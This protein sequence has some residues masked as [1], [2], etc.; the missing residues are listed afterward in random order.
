MKVLHLFIK[1]NN[2]KNGI[3][4]WHMISPVK[5]IKSINKLR[6]DTFNA[7]NAKLLKT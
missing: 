1:C 3:I 6:E 2:I 4:Q 7:Y 5:V